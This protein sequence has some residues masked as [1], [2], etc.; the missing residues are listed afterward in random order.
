MPAPARPDTGCADNQL[1]PDQTASPAAPAASDLP[2]Y[3][4]P[5]A[6]YARSAACS[7]QSC[8]HNLSVQLSA[9][10]VSLFQ[11]CIVSAGLLFYLTQQ[12]GNIAGRRLHQIQRL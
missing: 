3:A 10:S 2:D 12:L 7:M 5:A 1:Q 4:A 9:S 11:S 8:C 6:W